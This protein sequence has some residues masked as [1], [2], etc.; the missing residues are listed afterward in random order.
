VPSNRQANVAEA[1]AAD[2]GIP[3]PGVAPAPAGAPRT[4]PTFPSI[5]PQVQGGRTQDATAIKRQELV[6][7]QTNLAAAQQKLA[8]QAAATDPD[9]RKF[10]EDRV[11][12]HTDNIVSLNTELGVRTN[13]MP[14]A[15]AAAAAPVVNAMNAPSPRE[16]REARAKGYAF[17]SDGTM[18]PI[19]G[20]PADPA[21]QAA[22]TTQKLSVK[23]LQK[24][25]TDYPQ[26]RQAVKTV[27]NTMALIGATVDRLL[28]N[29]DGLNGISGLIYGRTV[30]LTAAA[31]AASADLGQLRNLAFV[32][33]L[34]ELRATSK[35][36]AGVGNVSNREG[37]RFENLKASLDTTQST[38]D[39]TSALTRLKNQAAFT[40]QTLQETFDDTYAYKTQTQ[41]ATLGTQLQAPATG[42]VQDGYRFKG[43]DPAKANN[44]EKVA[45]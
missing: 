30:A 39:L 36:G 5:S 34:T 13:N 4:P 32:Q 40:S 3:V 15:V 33:G 24:R 41:P 43:G 8:S 19:S 20:G 10:Y 44:W 28:A 31:R 23:D 18:S 26:A 38:S 6:R 1:R 45:K 35:T 22:Q 25:E 42:V 17:N 37:D 29:P 16:I 11:K 14:G 7:E 12:L 9:I 21:V 2:E 27:N